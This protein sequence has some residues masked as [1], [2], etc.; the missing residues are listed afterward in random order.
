MQQLSKKFKRFKAA[1]VQDPAFYEQCHKILEEI[2]EMEFKEMMN[3]EINAAPVF[4]AQ[5][6][7]VDP[8]DGAV[9]L[10][11]VLPV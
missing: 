2:A 5:S 8:D 10:A 4:A 6:P 1:F 7:L 9:D 3:M 11:D